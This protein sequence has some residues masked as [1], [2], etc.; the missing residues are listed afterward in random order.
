MTT[1]INTSRRARGVSMLMLVIVT[2]TVACGSTP[3]PTSPSTGPS[4]TP[5]PSPIP[6]PTPSSPTVAHLTGRVTDEAGSPLSGV[7]LEV[8]YSSGGAP[9]NPPSNCP[10]FATFCWFVVRTNGS[11]YYEAE[12][13]LSP[14]PLTGGVHAYIYSVDEG[15]A[16]N[17][18][19]LSF[20][21]NVVQNLRLRRPRRIDVGDSATVTV[22]PDSTLCS[23]LEDLYAFGYRCEYVTVVARNPGTLRVEM[24][25]DAGAVVPTVFWTTTGN[26]AGAIVRSSDPS[27]VSIPIT[28]GVYS[29]M[30]GI[31]VGTAAQRVTVHTSMK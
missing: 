30:A 31:P 17:V 4:P 16:T 7:L 1:D 15:F 21:S 6:A 22:E 28:G 11:G 20:S 10:G 26:Y 24:R 25:A 23:D 18:Q 8:D 27:T 12:F 14:K 9:S 13:Q 3:V 5:A 2:L 29:I 19:S